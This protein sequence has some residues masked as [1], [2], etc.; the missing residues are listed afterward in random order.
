MLRALA[1][2]LV[3]AG[4]ALWAIGSNV[5]SSD[6]EAARTCELTTGLQGFGDCQTSSGYGGALEV[7]G[8]IALGVGVLIGLMLV[9]SRSPAP[10]RGRD[11]GAPTR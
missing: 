10:D 5:K 11:E 9:F 6:Q 8:G 1:V 3:I 4:G 7:G 2:I